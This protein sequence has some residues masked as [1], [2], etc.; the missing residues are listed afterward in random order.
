MMRSRLLTITLALAIS[1]SSPCSAQF[2]LGKKKDNKQQPYES[3]HARTRRLLDADYLSRRPLGQRSGPVAASSTDDAFVGIT[4]WRLRPSRPDDDP[5]V[6]A[7]ISGDTT[8]EEWTRDRVSVDTSLTK[9]DKIRLSIETTRPGYLYVINRRQDFGGKISDDPYLI[10]P[11]LVARGGDNHV[12]PGMVVEIPSTPG[13]LSYFNLEHQV[14]EL[15]TILICPRPL[16]GV[17]VGRLPTRLSGEQVAD[18]ESKWGTKVTRLGKPGVLGDAATIAETEAAEGSRLLTQDDPLPQDVYHS[19]AN[20]GDP[21]LV[22]VLLS[23][24]FNRSGFVNAGGAIAGAGVVRLDSPRRRITARS[25]LT[26]LQREDTGYGLYSYILFGS[27][28]EYLDSNRWRR[29]YQAILAFLT[30]PTIEGLSRYVPPSGL[31]ITFLPINCSEHELPKLSLQPIA[32]QF[33]EERQAAHAKEHQ[34]GGKPFP[35]HG[36]SSGDTACTLVSNYDYSRAQKLLSILP[37]AHMEGPYIIST[38]K[39]LDKTQTLPAE[40]LYQDLSSVPPE[41]IN[42]WLREFM[43]Q[44]QEK[45]FWKTRSREQFVLRLRTTIGV[46]S[47]QMPD[48]GTAVTWAFAS[49]PQRK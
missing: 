34:A 42:L 17:Q 20:A 18:W 2:G 33:S 22:D 19:F 31:N 3:E 15:F 5:G 41:L 35:D 45:E 10:F 44:A 1:V 27:R 12:A 21:V 30:I 7:K 16:P 23:V 38:M 43:A 4:I 46:L 25:F 24:P 11:S 6:R 9:G 47:Q 8:T 32:F 49:A 39:P 37:Q 28:P 26:P 13:E 14:G 40:Y 29:Y 36:T 48:F